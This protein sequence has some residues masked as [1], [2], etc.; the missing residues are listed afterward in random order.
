LKAF[1]SNDAGGSLIG[2]WTVWRKGACRPS[3]LVEGKRK[4]AAVVRT[5]GKNARPESVEGL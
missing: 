2:G 5:R 3:V 1:G 4:E